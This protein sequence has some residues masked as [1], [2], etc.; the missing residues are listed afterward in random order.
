M[1]AFLME[2]ICQILIDFSYT[3]HDLRI[4]FLHFNIQIFF[5]VFTDGS[6]L[7]SD[8]KI[9]DMVF[10]TEVV[11]GLLVNGSSEVFFHY[12]SNICTDFIYLILHPMGRCCPFNSIQKMHGNTC[13]FRSRKMDVQIFINLCEKPFGNCSQIRIFIFQLIR[14]WQGYI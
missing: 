3:F 11:K 6:T 2:E 4:F 14:I 8:N 10:E 9:F 5:I 7:F 1:G 13:N 12:C